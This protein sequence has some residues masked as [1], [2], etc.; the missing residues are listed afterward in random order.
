MQGGEK[1]FHCKWFS[2]YIW[3][4]NWCICIDAF[5]AATIC[6]NWSKFGTSWWFGKPQEIWMNFCGWNLKLNIFY[7]ELHEWMKFHKIASKKVQSFIHES[8]F[9]ENSHM[10]FHGC[11]SIEIWMDFNAWNQLMT[12][13]IF[14]GQLEILNES[15]WKTFISSY[16][17]M[18]FHHLLMKLHS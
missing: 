7:D 6:D 4:V 2:L 8:S 18:E 14:C 10:I 9:M 3:W 15:Y 5:V 12:W 11:S 17:V 13:T 1:K 16:D